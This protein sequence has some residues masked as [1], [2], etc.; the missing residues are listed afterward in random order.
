[1]G[2]DVLGRMPS[3]AVL[4]PRE[5]WPVARWLRSL[6][7]TGVLAAIAL[8]A[9][10]RAADPARS[11]AT[12][13][14]SADT[15]T[16][17]ADFGYEVATS[18]TG[19]SSRVAVLRGHVRITQADTV[20]TAGQAIGW[21]SAARRP[22]S[23]IRMS[24]YLE[25][26]VRVRQPGQTHSRPI[27]LHDL[28]TS[29]SLPTVTIRRRQRHPTP[30]VHDPLYRRATAH[31]QRRPTERRSLVAYQ[32]DSPPAPPLS[33]PTG[34][35]RRIQFFP[36]T[37]VPFNVTIDKSPGTTPAENMLVITG[38]I[39]LVV[40]VVE[41]NKTQ[42][43]FGSNTV[44]LS[45]D[46]AVIWTQLNDGQQLTAQLE[47]GTETPIQVYL[48][49]NIEI[50]MGGHVLR[51]RRAVYDV[52]EGR[53]LLLDADLKAQLPGARVP[54][55]VRAERIRKEGDQ[56]FHAHNAWATTS[57]FGKPGFRVQARDMFLDR[58]K[59][60]GWLGSSTGSSD[61]QVYWL[62]TQNNLL[63]VDDVPIFFAPNLGGP[64]AELN[65]PLRRISARH[66]N[67]FG[68]QLETTWSLFSLL[69][70]DPV[71]GLD[72][73]LNAD[74]FSKRG[75]RIGSGLSYERNGLL[76]LPGEIRGWS[77][78]AYLHDDGVDNLGRD[79]RR[80]A[81]ESANRG[82]ARVIHRHDLPGRLSVTGELGY[83]SDRNLLEQYYEEE[84]D[85][86]KD[87]ETLLYLEQL[88]E[89]T[90]WS[91]L[92]RPQ[93]NDFETTTEWLPRGDLY[94]F[95]QP[96]LGGWLSWS[97]HTSAGYGR[98]RPA[99]APS[100]L[101]D[102]FDPLG[103]TTNAAGAVLM[104]RHELSLP[105]AMGPAPL[106]PYVMA[107]EAYW[108]EGFAGTDIDRH[109]FSGG[110][111]G[112]LSFWKAFPGV[113]SPVFGLNGLAHKMTFE[114]DLSWTETTRGLDEIPQYNEIDDNAQERFRYRLLGNSFAGTLPMGFDPRSMAV[115]S[116][117]GLGLMVPW[118]EL[119]AD[120][121]ALRMAWRQRL[122]TKVGPVGQQRIR[123]WMTLDLEATWFPRADRDN[124]GEDFGLLG[125]MYRWHV[126]DR[127]TL[128][129]DTYIDLFDDAPQM[130]NLGMLSQRT[131]RGTLYA[132]MRQ[133][134][135]G[136]LDSQ[137]LTASFSYRM[138][139]KWVSTVATAY[140]LAEHRNQGQ[141]LMITRI[142][143]DFLV[144]VGA[145]YDESRG[146]A[147]FQLSLEPRFG[148][149]NARNPQL[150]TLL[151]QR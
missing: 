4:S 102:A 27:L 148:A 63:L 38:G 96:L 150:A 58:R 36:R 76:G 110:V 113:R 9:A 33:E 54:L 29:A 59:L 39:N 119:V 84:F 6:C 139:P 136:G 56:S 106:V 134:R 37:S 124:F 130:W 135:G 140:D 40:D 28:E 132:G 2:E 86:E 91:L 7:I 5:R 77:D 55:R 142:G 133:I 137:I 17:T 72:W 3:H 61:G 52:R 43:L 78:G 109:L 31:R 103:Y 34:R 98:L 42:A 146:A 81:P 67:I 62:T 117:T 144:H 41:S 25:E 50:R 21:I 111:R 14:G 94:V 126:S 95:S 145:S 112:S 99:D 1:M 129:A 90:A 104:S 19:G 49:G 71:E 51:A 68:G 114:T 23:G 64:A 60:P 127:T 88:G 53:A 100:D 22:E 123:N 35:R 75:P 118:H 82:R 80:I 141:S 116:G 101:T 65:I 32:P 87:H 24:L 8:P 12:G 46:R 83:L 105:L 79:R 57:P 66:D 149:M 45:A 85:E 138:S 115:R 147:G 108:T 74:Y 143:G 128:L 69:G 120:Q 11:D 89:T 30:L 16:V 73:T 92:A 44:D 18:A 26:N 93:L 121:Q 48:E 15:I 131:T 125:A 107:E 20:I 70:I 122:Q 151:G 47:L 97:S 13:S 10:A